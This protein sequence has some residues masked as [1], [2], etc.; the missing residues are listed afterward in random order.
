VGLV[1]QVLISRKNQRLMVYF[2]TSFI[3]YENFDFA[4]LFFKIWYKV[5]FGDEINSKKSKKVALFLL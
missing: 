5:I 1:L 3:F 4:K 2:F